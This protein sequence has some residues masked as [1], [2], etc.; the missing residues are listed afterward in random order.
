MLKVDFETD[1]GSL[2]LY[3]ETGQRKLVDLRVCAKSFFEAQHGS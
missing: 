2:M 3:T 1:R